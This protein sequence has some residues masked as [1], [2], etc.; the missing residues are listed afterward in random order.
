MLLHVFLSIN[1]VLWICG[2]FCDIRHIFGGRR[3]VCAHLVFFF[4]IIFNNSATFSCIHLGSV[5]KQQMVATNCLDANYLHSRWL[6]IMAIYTHLPT[7]KHSS[8]FGCCCYIWVCFF[9]T[10]WTHNNLFSSFCS[11]SLH[12]CELAN[13]LQKKHFTVIHV[14]N[15]MKI[16]K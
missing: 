7:G 5:Q 4:Y 9:L 11:S 15:K 6:V 1:L 8:A 16:T 3:F 2:A 13:L 14:S 12:F 10:V